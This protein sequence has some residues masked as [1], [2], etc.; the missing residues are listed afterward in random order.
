MKVIV[1]SFLVLRSGFW[2]VVRHDNRELDPEPKARQGPLPLYGVLVELRADWK[3]FSET[4]G[5]KSCAS[6]EYPFFKGC[7]DRDHCHEYHKTVA[8]PARRPGLPH[9]GVVVPDRAA[10]ERSGRPGVA[11]TFVL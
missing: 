3:Q 4:F 10:C 1:C 6:S 9:S 7:A 11:E 2:P 8:T 5:F